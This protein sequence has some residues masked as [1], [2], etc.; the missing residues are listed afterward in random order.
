MEQQT[1]QTNLQE[2]QFE[3]F[4]DREIQTDLA[5]QVARAKNNLDDD[6]L[7]VV[8]YNPISGLNGMSTVVP[9]QLASETLQAQNNLYDEVG[10][11]DNYLVNKLQYSS[12]FALSQALSAEQCDSVALAINQIEKNMGFILAD[13][14][15]IGKGRVNAAILRYAK[16]NGYIPVFITEK[17]HLFTAIYRD[18]IDIGGITPEKT[19]K[20]EP[21]AGVPL[22][23]NGYK[24]GG[25]EKVF[26]EATNQFVKYSKPSPNSILNSEGKVVIEAMKNE[27][28]AEIMETGKFPKTYSYM[29]GRG[30]EQKKVTLHFDYVV[31]TY[32]QL[33]SKNKKQQYLLELAQNNKLIICMDECHNAA[34]TKS[35]TGKFMKEMIPLTQGILFSSATFS[36]S[37]DTMDLYVSKTNL[38]TSSLGIDKLIDVINLGGERLIEVLSSNL[39]LSGQMV[40]RQRSYDNCTVLYNFMSDS[41]KSDLFRKYDKAIKVFK[42]ILGFFNTD[43]FIEAKRNAIKKFAEKNGVELADKKSENEDLQTWLNR[44]H[45]KYTSSFS[46][47][48]AEGNQFNF[49][50]TLLFALKAD[51]VATQSIEQL[52]VQSVNTSAIDKSEFMSNRKPVIAVRSTLEGVYA[53]LGWKV[54]EE[55]YKADFS[56]YIASFLKDGVTGSITLKQVLK[57]KSILQKKISD[58]LTISLDDYPDGGEMYQKE[59]KNIDE[60]NLEIPLSPIDYLID[61]IENT[62]RQSWDKYGDGSVF[63][64]VGEVTGRK[65]RL[66]A[67]EFEKMPNGEINIKKPIKWVLEL[68]KKDKNKS[69]TFKQFNIGYFDCLLIN[70]SGSTG[71]DAHSSSNFK[72][73]RPRVMIIHQVELDVNTEVQKRGRIYRTGMV[74]YPTYVYAISRIPSEIRRLL[75]LVKKMRKLDANTTANQKQSQKLI[76]IRDSDGNPIEDILN[77]HGDEVLDEFLSVPANAEYLVY[78]EISESEYNPSTDFSIE[79]FIR[80]LELSDSSTQEYFYNTI[81]ELYRQKKEENNGFQDLETN[82]SDLRCSIETR[83]TISQGKNTNPFDSSVFIEEDYAYA[84]DKPFT[85]EKVD[86]LMY[87]ISK[88]KDPEEYY[89]EFLEDYKNWFKI[90]IEEVKESVNKPKLEGLKEEEIKIEQKGYEEKIKKA[91]QDAK[92]EFDSIIEILTMDYD[93]NWYPKNKGTNYLLKPNNPILIPAVFDECYIQGYTISNYNYGKFVG[94]RILNTAKEKYSPMNIELIFCQLSGKGRISIKPTV[95]G[96]VVLQSALAHTLSQNHLSGSQGIL[97]NQIVTRIKDWQTDPNRRD[98]TTKIRLLTGNILNA[99]D[100][101][102]QLVQKYKNLYSPVLT[103]LKFTTANEKALRYGIKLNKTKQSKLE[104]TEIPKVFTLNS[105]ELV[106]LMY[107]SQYRV[108]CSHVN[109]DSGSVDFLINFS[110]GNFNIYIFG[111]MNPNKGYNK[112]VLF[113]NPIYFD[114]EIYN[115]SKKAQ[116]NF[117]TSTY[118]IKSERSSKYSNP[119]VKYFYAYIPEKNKDLIKEFF[120]F[121]YSK[122]PMT[123][124]VL[125]IQDEYLIYKRKDVESG[126]EEEEEGVFRYDILP[127]YKVMKDAIEKSAKYDK[128]IQSTEYPKNGTA[129]FKKRLRAVEAAQLQLIP[130]DSTLKDMVFDTFALISDDTEKQKLKENIFKAIQ[131]GKS[132]RDVTDIVIKALKGRVFSMKSV[133]GYAAESRDFVGQ[134][135]KKFKNGEIELPIVIVSEQEKEEKKQK[136]S[137][138]LNLDNAENYMIQLFDAVNKK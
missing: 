54:G 132:D 130:L 39:C 108:D 72:D 1:E 137:K 7:N 51:F 16:V 69:V 95:R 91:T 82:V 50:E 93:G 63:Y 122:N 42:D 34:G 123:V 30:K 113:Q 73:Q 18:F 64:N 80:K 20:G 22:I 46:A 88:N 92:Y 2:Q 131:E 62:P 26:D 117:R 90:H 118:G 126:I 35:T 37:P 96:R 101:G 83:F 128:Y 76:A 24:S 111:G 38:K 57:T 84:E 36:K 59:V 48:Q 52:S 32:S 3:Q 49:I 75:M 100:I 97:W 58:E 116:L 78:K 107:Q 5:E 21:I 4:I 135:F 134:V 87:E 70:E 67:V 71:E 66:K 17:P 86:K 120:A 47:G 53:D 81:N 31:L 40:R 14:A 60:I 103:F 115:E 106:D 23:I 77:I 45:G 28:V 114:D 136:K 98:D 11:I 27:Y 44:N 79:K 55:I 85:K 104:P 89:M 138:P 61:I 124:S 125:N 56:L 105:P 109:E 129:Y 8:P 99:Y 12:K 133:F 6:T 65:L 121:L 25:F 10:D 102:L 13:M 94:V 74:N 41:Q 33:S 127:D 68:N 119:Y 112:K 43:N 29:V 19:K 9:L 15:G 110:D